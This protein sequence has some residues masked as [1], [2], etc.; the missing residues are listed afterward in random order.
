[1]IYICVCVCVCVFPRDAAHL[2][3]CLHIYVFKFICQYVNICVCKYTMYISW[4]V[5]IYV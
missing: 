1:M 5:Q 4:G 3:M 2:Y